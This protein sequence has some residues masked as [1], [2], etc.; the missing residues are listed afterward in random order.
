M[1]DRWNVRKPRSI[2]KTYSRRVGIWLRFRFR[3]LERRKRNGMW[4][5]TI[6]S[7]RFACAQASALKLTPHPIP[8]SLSG[9]L[10]QVTVATSPPAAKGSS[11]RSTVFYVHPTGSPHS[12]MQNFER[13]VK[14]D[15]YRR[16]SPSSHLRNPA[17]AVGAF[18]LELSR[19]QRS[20]FV[21]T[22]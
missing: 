10:L 19:K 18:R 2:L 6:Q 7:G 16:T 5:K 11:N 14:G 22:F 21:K 12:Q 3:N 15:L 13:G 17:F 9:R 8:L 20:A 4:L 1:H